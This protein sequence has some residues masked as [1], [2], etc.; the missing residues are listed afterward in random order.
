MLCNIKVINSCFRR[1]TSDHFY[2]NTRGFSPNTLC[3]G[4]KLFYAT[5]EFKVHV[6]LAL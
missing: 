3:I 5:V 6:K 2:N 4:L 1:H